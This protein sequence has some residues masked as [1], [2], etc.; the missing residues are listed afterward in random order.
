MPRL[1]LLFSIL[2][3]AADP[4]TGET[5][6]YSINWPSGL[7]LGEATLTSQPAESPKGAMSLQFQAEASIPGFSILE[8]LSATADPGGCSISFTKDSL[9]GKRVLQE[10][11]EFDQA[12]RQ[13]TR[14]TKN[15]GKSV[16]PA[17]E[18]ARDALA[19]LQFLRHQ[20]RAGRLPSGTQ[21]VFAGAAYDLSVRFLRVA[22]VPISG[23]VTETEQLA[24]SVRGPKTEIDF[25]LFF[26]RDP[27]RTPVLA[28]IPF[29]LGTFALE[30]MPAPE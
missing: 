3:T 23:K 13:A 26:A 11:T 22:R 29:E 21:T 6:R 25:E 27:A 18:C 24:V 14:Q 2:A 15:G 4:P 17:P 8:N 7:S 1:L 20:L 12:A 9:R 30:L 16:L 10:T 5:L 19:F 28:K